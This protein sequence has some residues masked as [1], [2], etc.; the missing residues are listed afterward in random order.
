L[1]LWPPPRPLAPDLEWAE[2]IGS[3]WGNP[4]TRPFAELLID[5]EEDP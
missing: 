4:V 3:Y 1:D 2:Q 5:A